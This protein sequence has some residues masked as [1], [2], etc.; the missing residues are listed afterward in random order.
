MYV[1][2]GTI[3]TPAE[4]DEC[5]QTYDGLQRGERLYTMSC[6]DK[7]CKWNV[8]GVQGTLLSA[9]IEPV[10]ISSIVLGKLSNP[11]YV[12]SISNLM[13]FGVSGMRAD[14]WIGTDVNVMNLS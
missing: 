4:I 7:L 2:E 11:Y 10:Y 14:T 13:H 1:G 5:F 9:F 3:P 8:L 12:F 6:S